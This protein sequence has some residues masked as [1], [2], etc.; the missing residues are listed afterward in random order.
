MSSSSRS[1]P[2][3]NNVAPPAEAAEVQLRLRRGRLVGVS[4]GIASLLGWRPDDWIGHG[5]EEFL[6]PEGLGGV[7]VRLARL[8]PGQRVIWRDRLR[9]RD[10]RWHWVQ[11]EATPDT[12]GDHDGVDAVARLVLMAEGAEP[13]PG[14]LSRELRCDD[15]TDLLNRREMMR[16]LDRL[17]GEERRQGRAM[18]V[19]F[20]DLDD[21]KAIND[22]WGHRSGDEVLREV[23]RR[24][25]RHLRSTD[26]AARIGGDELLVVLDGVGGLDDALSVADALRLA[27]AQPLEL[28][29]GRGFTVPTLSIG[30]TLARPHELTTELIERADAAMYRAK[31]KG[32]NQVVAIAA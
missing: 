3:G 16:H 32:R 27:V 30:V 25:R 12:G 14:D 6:H 26:L 21:F 17:Q 19:L 24:L 22:R 28:P 10:G 8:G 2:P 7:D 1:S 5:V 11:L 9:S 23:A 15:L 20:C 29:D 4:E 31:R 13:P 18:A